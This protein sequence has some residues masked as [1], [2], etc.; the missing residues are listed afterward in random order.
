MTLGLR[1]DR[2]SNNGDPNDVFWN[3]KASI[4]VNIHELTDVGSVF[5][6]LKPRFAYGRS[7]RFAGFSDRFNELSPGQ[8]A[9]SAGLFTAPLR[10]NPDVAPETQTEFEF[11][12]DLG[13]WNNRILFNATYYIKT[14]DDL[15][16]R[17]QVPASSGFS[18]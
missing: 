1:G 8:I 11:G 3:P 13:F 18:N 15:L 7:A 9:G 14:I 16:L 5:S 10:G 12:A 2:S 6:Q 4:A 17:A